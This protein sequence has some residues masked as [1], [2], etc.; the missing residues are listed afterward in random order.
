VQVLKCVAHSNFVLSVACH[1]GWLPAARYDNLRNVRGFDRIG[2]LD[3]DWKNYSFDRHLEA[4]K[5]VE[6]MITV[7]RD[8]E[9]CE[10]L[11]EI[12]SQAYELNSYCDYV[13]VVP[14]DPRLAGDMNGLIPSEFVLGYSVPTRYGKTGIPP[15]AFT[16]AVHLLG[17]SPQVQRRL[18]DFMPVVSFDCNRFTID[19]LYG[20]YFDGL[21]FRPHPVGGYERCI[22]E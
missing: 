9:R 2:F 7:A 6:P 15:S 21:R 20:D 12:I 5:A 11:A 16:R 17:G 22:R 8:I 3:I 1:Y 10:D 14:K 18:A 4:V 13:V 19:A